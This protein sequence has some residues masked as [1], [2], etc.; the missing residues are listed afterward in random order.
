[1]MPPLS[2][3]RNEALLIAAR[4]LPRSAD[5]AISMVMAAMAS[6]GDCA[7]M[8]RVYN[9]TASPLFRAQ[10]SA[11]DAAVESMVV[12]HGLKPWIAER[13]AEAIVTDSFDHPITQTRIDGVVNPILNDIKDRAE[14]IYTR[15]AQL[16]N[17]LFGGAAGNPEDAAVCLRILDQLCQ[18]YLDTGEMSDQIAFNLVVKEL[19]IVNTRRQPGG[20][21]PIAVPAN[22]VPFAFF[23]DAQIQAAI[24]GLPVNRQ[25]PVNIPTNMNQKL[26]R[27]TYEAFINTHCLKLIDEVNTKHKA[28]EQKAPNFRELAAAVFVAGVSYDLKPEQATQLAMRITDYYVSHQGSLAGMDI[29][30][31]AATVPA[32]PLNNLQRYKLSQA[33]EAAVNLPTP[34]EADP[35]AAGTMLSAKIF[36]LFNN[37]AGQA[38]MAAM[39]AKARKGTN[40]AIGTAAVYA[41]GISQK[42][43]NRSAYF[44]MEQ[45]VLY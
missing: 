21:G 18:H 33:V 40:A 32:I 25:A 24:P 45:Q 1:M 13:L 39:V 38:A 42:A 29:D 19:N 11:I 2:K 22:A 44:S 35:V 43:D 27:C 36:P 4:I 10:A 5:Y 34:T 26:Y 20:P 15:Q 6:N 17:A 37:P 14:V 23:N 41:E 30:T 12:H 7:S 8:L 31:L 16:G 9:Q 28:Q 3:T